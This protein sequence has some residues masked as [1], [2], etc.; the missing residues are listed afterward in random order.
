[1]FASS[2]KAF[3]EALL[4][5]TTT[6]QLALWIGLFGRL[7]FPR[8]SRRHCIAKAVLP[9]ASVLICARNEAENIARHLPKVL[10][11]EYP[12]FEVIVVDDDSSDGT[13]D[14][15]HRLQEQY[16]HLRA[17]HL[18]PKATPGKKAAQ[19]MAIRAARHEVLVFTDADC[20]P[21]SCQW[22]Q[23]MVATLEST[24]PGR[25]VEITLGYGPYASAPSWLNRWARFET[26][27]TAMQYLSLAS[28]GMPYM[29]VGRNLAW[30]KPL[31]ARAGGFE[32]H[33]RL[34]SGDDDLF[35]NAVATAQNTE[36]CLTPSAFV[37]STAPLSWAAWIRQKRRHLST[38]SFYRRKHQVVLAALAGSQALHLLLAVAC[39]IGGHS[40]T[41]FLFW[42]MRTAVA[43]TLFCLIAHRFCERGLCTRFPL[44]DVALC[45]YY[46]FFVPYSLLSR[47]TDTLWK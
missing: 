27:Y 30:R 9:P 18:S 6:A 29:G 37:Y 43:W 32:A 24:V 10:E 31:F 1:M 41:A 5:A 15:L 7:A 3:G 8:T 35:I 11:Q 33:S 45:A 47:Q 2:S 14:V 39:T 12:D 16:P 28:A 36:I 17:L 42:G 38:G 40:I 20:C 22:L 13:L 46:L 26:L 23:Q 21:A 34:A 25:R 19:E 4:I 44:L